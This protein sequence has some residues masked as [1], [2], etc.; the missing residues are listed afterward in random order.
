M[1]VASASLCGT[2]VISS[3]RGELPTAGTG[4]TASSLAGGSPTTPVEDP[5]EAHSAQAT[6]TA[7]VPQLP[8]TSPYLQLLMGQRVP[9][10]PYLQ[11][12][13]K[14]GN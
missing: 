6:C 3:A 8:P 14:L 4:D 9:R 12:I 5:A 11:V 13:F 2:L 1:A 7:I 10:M